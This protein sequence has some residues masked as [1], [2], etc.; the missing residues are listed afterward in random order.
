M[1]YRIKNP[2]VLTVIIGNDTLFLVVSEKSYK[3]C[4]TILEY[5]RFT[6]TA[7]ELIDGIIYNYSALKSEIL[8]RVPPFLLH[9]S[10]LTIIIDNNQLINTVSIS[11]Q[12]VT[13]ASAEAVT[14]NQIMHTH[15]IGPCKDT[16][17]LLYT[18]AISQRA[19]LHYRLF[20]SLFA[21]PLLAITCSM[22]P[23][24]HAYRDYKKTVFRLSELAQEVMRYEN[25]FVDFFTQESMQQLMPALPTLDSVYKKPFLMAYGNFVYQELAHE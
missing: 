9:S 13:Q 14:D 6:G 19:L 11:S 20:A 22:H 15:Y 25:S 3:H 4:Y 24:I 10:F 21:M 17:H 1:W 18:C 7:Y 16:D 8:S 2:V 23:L 12:I 5:H